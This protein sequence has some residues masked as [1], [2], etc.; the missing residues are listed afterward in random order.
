MSS[1]CG[2]FGS[3]SHIDDGPG[4]R[5]P[6]KRKKKQLKS[7]AQILDGPTNAR[8]SATSKASK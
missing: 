8:H 4:K 1:F 6:D 2:C 7:S 3:S 5:K